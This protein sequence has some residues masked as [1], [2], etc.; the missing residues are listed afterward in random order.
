MAK[1]TCPDCGFVH[2]CESNLDS[3]ETRANKTSKLKAS[4]PPC[5]N[6]VRTLKDKYY[7]NIHDNAKVEVIY[8]AV[9]TCST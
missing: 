6:N 8:Y 4:L 9:L 1:V 2:E 7:V 3:S 5:L